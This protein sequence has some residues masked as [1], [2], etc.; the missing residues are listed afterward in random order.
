MALQAQLR[1]PLATDR[2]M[3]AAQVTGTEAHIMSGGQATGY[4][5]MVS[6][7]GSTATMS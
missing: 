6:K 1:L 2:T 4:G 3:L 5:G 7:C